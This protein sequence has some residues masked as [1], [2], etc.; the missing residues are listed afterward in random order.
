MDDDRAG[1]PPR[2]ELQRAI[3]DDD[4]LGQRRARGKGTLGS[5]FNGKPPLRITG[6]MD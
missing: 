2:V 4:T 6:R 3:R 1:G 5:F